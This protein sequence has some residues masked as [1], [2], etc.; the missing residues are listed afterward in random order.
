MIEPVSAHSAYIAQLTDNGF[1]WSNLFYLFILIVLPVV[2]KI[3]DV[4]VERAESKPQGKDGGSAAK[5]RRVPK[6][7]PVEPTLPIAKPLRV[8]LTEEKPAPPAPVARPVP[9]QPPPPPPV[10]HPAAA[11]APQPRLK[12]RKRQ[13][14]IQ[15]T[16]AK[17][18]TVSGV[19]VGAADPS[20]DVHAADPTVRVRQADPAVN[21][22]ASRPAVQVRDVIVADVDEEAVSGTHL[23]GSISAIDLRRAVIMSEVLRPPLALRSAGGWQEHAP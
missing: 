17:R 12:R 15:P 7:R 21:V 4:F 2:N 11:S 14:A 5:G 19:K 10:Q 9:N 13:A 6:L 8:G 18:H 23:V 22:S 16:L 1:D 3:K 20:V